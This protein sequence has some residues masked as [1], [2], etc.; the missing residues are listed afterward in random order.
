MARDNQTENRQDNVATK[1]PIRI[2]KTGQ[3]G[4]GT[5]KA[6]KTP[7]TKTVIFVP[8]TAY[9][10][11]VKMLG[12]EEIHMVKATVYRVKYVEKPG[13]NLKKKRKLCRIR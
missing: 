12:A 7:E 3:V 2:V 8:Q 5:N 10:M 4:K 6:N 1:D 13:Q 9:S 11:L